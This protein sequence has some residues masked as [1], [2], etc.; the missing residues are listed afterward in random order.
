M[1]GAA[2]LAY[3]VVWSRMLVVTLGNSSDATAMVLSSF[4]LGIAIGALLLGKVADRV[5]SP[6]KMY[7]VLELTLALFA[8]VIPSLIDV[9]NGI[10]ALRGSFET[11]PGTAVLRLFVAGLLVVIPSLVMGA[12]IPIL[13]RA[14]S[15]AATDVRKRIGLI[16]GLNTIGAAAGSAFTGFMAIPAY[17]FTGTSIIAACLNIS[18]AVLVLGVRRFIGEAKRSDLNDTDSVDLPAPKKRIAFAALL[19]AATSGITMLSAEVLWAR[20]LTFVFGHDTYA[21]AALLAIV[22]LGLGVGGVVH[23]KLSSFNSLAVTNILAGLLGLT[24]IGSYWAAAALVTEVGRDPFSLGS[25]GALA[26]SLRLEFYR[27][28]LYTPILVFLPAVISGALFPAACSLYTGPLD[29]AG[30]RIGTATLLNGLGSAMGSLLTSFLL[31]AW[32]GIHNALVA[33]ALFAAAS[34]VTIGIIY[35]KQHGLKTGLLLQIPSASILVIAL[36]MP[37]SLTRTMLQEAVGE[38]HQNLLFYEEGR[39][40]TVSVTRNTINAEKQLFMNAVNEVT[41]RLVHDQ[42]FKLLGHLGPLLH[43]NP[44]NGAMV[45]LGAGLSAGAALVHPLASLDVVELSNTIPKAAALWTEENNDVLNDPRFT[46]HIADGRHYLLSTE[47]QFDV[48]MV[49]STHPKA[50]DSWIL[51]TKE[52][53]ELVKDRLK[54][55]GIAVQWLPLHGLSEREFKIIVRTF[56]EVFPH[57]ALWTNVGFEVY[58]QAA[59]LKMV[60]QKSPMRIDYKELALRLKEP[61]IAGDLAPFGMDDIYDVLDCYLAGPKAIDAWTAGL[62]AQSDDRPIVPYTTE[63]SAGRRMTAPLLL[64]VRSS[65]IKLALML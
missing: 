39:T 60:A 46:L 55:E 6:L 43:P 53:Y 40:G 50:V 30:K 19:A 54:E 64:G 5:R 9:I 41:T 61:R 27:E 21:F 52:F 59:Y 3:E 25:V 33:S 29:E 49:D 11:Q 7:A 18:A 12:T 23:R 16:Y 65:L 58:G 62:P 22:L 31:V 4:M 44:K 51:Y 32:I 57:A 45:C 28:I 56:Y 1:S 34:A 14:L 35:I 10:D 38:R 2:S 47:K 13:V 15:S 8:F 26:T 20:V 17:G 37:A 36:L 42:S 24:I 48:I 63:F